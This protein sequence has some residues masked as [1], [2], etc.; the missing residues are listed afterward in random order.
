MLA[1]ESR[2]LAAPAELGPEWAQVEAAP[3]SSAGHR[4]AA[5]TLV[6]DFADRPTAADRR[7]GWQ[8]GRTDI[9]VADNRAGAFAADS[10]LAGKQDRADRGLARAEEDN[11]PAR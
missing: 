11:R 5:D 3:D 7:R 6:R 10:P 2:A 4:A 1:A 8:A 9:P